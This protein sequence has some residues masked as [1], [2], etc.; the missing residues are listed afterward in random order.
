MLGDKYIEQRTNF[1]ADLWTAFTEC[2]YVEEGAGAMKGGLVWGK[3][4]KA[5]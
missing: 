3:S 4:K 2:K 1:F 5:Q